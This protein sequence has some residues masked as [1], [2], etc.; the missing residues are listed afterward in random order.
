M[1][2]FRYQR[3][4]TMWGMIFVLFVLGFC[5]F[6]TFKLFPVYM[7]DIKVSNALKSVSNEL[8]GGAP[9]RTD[10]IV[11]LVKRM[12]ID[13]FTG[14]NFDKDLTI[15]AKGT[16]REVLIVYDVVVP[17][18]ANISLLLDFKHSAYVSGGG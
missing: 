1:K 2:S 3:G 17:L 13:D 8:K 9:T 11:A 18:F 16:G 5:L 7:N 4:M 6:I 15:Q 12:N 14:V 10:I